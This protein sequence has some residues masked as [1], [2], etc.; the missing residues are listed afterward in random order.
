MLWGLLRQSRR[1]SNRTA[2]PIRLGDVGDISKRDIA[3]A[4]AVKEHEPLY[5]AVLGF[6]VKTLPDA[7]EEAAARGVTIFRDNIIYHVIDNYMLWFKGRRDAGLD[8]IS[9]RWSNRLN[10]R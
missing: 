5:A 3:E 7:E 6:N 1:F 2:Y 4:A 10:C 9:R 8:K